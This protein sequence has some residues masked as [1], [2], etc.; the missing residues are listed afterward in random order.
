MATGITMLLVSATRVRRPQC[1]VVAAV[2]SSNCGGSDV[3]PPCSS[4][5]AQRSLNRHYRVW[6][7][8]VLLNLI[9]FN[10]YYVVLRWFAL[11]I[12]IG[13]NYLGLA[14]MEYFSVRVYHSGKFRGNV[15]A[16]KY[17]GAEDTILDWCNHD[18]WSL[19]EG[20]GTGLKEL[21]GD[22]DPME[23]AN[24]G[25]AQGL[26]E[27]YVVHKLSVPVAL[28]D[29]PYDIGY[30]DVGGA[31]NVPDGD[32]CELNLVLEAQHVAENGPG[33]GVE[34]QNCADSG[35][36]VV[37]EAQNVEVEIHVDTEVGVKN[38]KEGLNAYEKEDSRGD[39]GDDDDPYYQD[40]S[41]LNFSDSKDDFIGDDDLF[42]VDITLGEF[43]LEIRDSKQAKAGKVKKKKGKETAGV[44]VS[45]G[46]SDDEGI[47]SDELEDLHIEDGDGDD[48]DGSKV[49]HKKKFPIHKEL[50]DMS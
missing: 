24:V 42:D 29:F 11:L 49:S 10:G 43:Q 31:V 25:V 46:L 34:A 32:D 27:L 36:S 4:I 7:N 37:M 18:K 8:A 12:Y 50:K 20:G 19:L 13:V 40:D 5:S 28:D 47:N 35:P 26:V 39:S 15:W 9:S 17:V 38:S 3:L 33:I 16:R 2:T 14:T 1:C 41:D 30:I 21:S 23:M 44:R 22:I 48:E 6:T 45:S